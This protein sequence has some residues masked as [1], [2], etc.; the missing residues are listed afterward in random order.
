[1]SIPQLHEIEQVELVSSVR[2]SLS[3][4]LVIFR[5]LNFTLHDDVV[6]LDRKERVP[7]WQHSSIVEIQIQLDGVDVYGFDEGSW[8]LIRLQ[9]LYATL[10]YVLTET[11]IDV[12]FAVSDRLLLPVMFHGAPVDKSTLRHSLSRIRDELITETGEEPGSK[13]LA[14]LIHSTYP[15]H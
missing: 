10:P 11:F 9:Y 13:G 8:N 14:I 5:S 6:S 12:A 1:M 3:E 4:L 2:K 7:P 15:R